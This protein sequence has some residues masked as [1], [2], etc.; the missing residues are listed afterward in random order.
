MVIRIRCECNRVFQVEDRFAGKKC[1]CPGCGQIVNIPDPDNLETLKE[2]LPTTPSK[3]S[4]PHPSPPIR[5]ATSSAAEVEEP[6]SLR[7]GRKALGCVV[8]LIA[9][10]VWFC[11]AV[12]MPILGFVVSLAI[13]AAAVAYLVAGSVQELIDG[14]WGSILQG[15]R[16]PVVHFLVVGGL[17]LLF[18]VTSMM[19][20][21]K[22]EPGGDNLS[23][24]RHDEKPGSGQ[25]DI[26]SSP[27]LH[28]ALL[29]RIR[30]DPDYADWKAVE[31]ITAGFKPKFDF[32]DDVYRK[33]QP[34]ARKWDFTKRNEMFH[35]YVDRWRPSNKDDSARWKSLTR[36]FA[37]FR[38]ELK[39]CIYMDIAL[40]DVRAMS[41]SAAAIE[42]L[43]IRNGM[44][45]KGEKSPFGR[46]REWRDTTLASSFKKGSGDKKSPVVPYIS[47][48]HDR[49]GRVFSVSILLKCR[50]DIPV[51]EVLKLPDRERKLNSVRAF[52]ATSRECPQWGKELIRI[53]CGDESNELIRQLGV[54][55]SA[56]DSRLMELDEKP[57][58]DDGCWLKSN[59]GPYNLT[60]WVTT[61]GDIFAICIQPIEWLEIETAVN[62]LVKD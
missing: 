22:G 51:L 3:Q 55:A 33:L 29:E 35:E 60:V 54:I 1:K 30:S 15:R 18:S 43:A 19:G 57:D 31:Q 42:A 56:T 45:R 37:F 34:L 13:V 48:T 28:P 4:P 38:D 10:S 39:T 50:G 14:A 41:G 46:R 36:H 5:Q 27:D 26:K 25:S 52:R 9:A 21:H 12:S 24:T 6:A 62:E 58:V 44:N 53:T 7:N 8:T 47:W 61:L 11:I 17:G 16:A 20:P 23:S 2:V 32:L 49:S 40:K 59:H